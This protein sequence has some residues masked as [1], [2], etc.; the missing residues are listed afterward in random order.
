VVV[1][2]LAVTGL[3]VAGSSSPK[4]TKVTIQLK[5][6]TQSQF[7]G[8]YAAKA[9]GYYKAAGL[10]VNLKVGGPDIVNEQTVLSKQAEFGVDW[11][12]SLLANRD[13]GNDLVNIAQI[14][15]RSGTTEVT[16]K[17]SGIN[18]FK[19]MRGKKFGVWI[20]GNEFEQE[21][22]LVKNGMDPKKDV[23]LVKQDFTMVPFLNGEVDAASAMTYN[24][25]AQV[26][27]TKNPDTGK[28]VWYYQHLP[29][30]QWDF[31]WA[32]ERHVVRLPVRGS[33]RTVIV[34]AG[35][36][37]IFD[38]VEAEGGEYLF[39]MDLG[40]QNVVKSINPR[41]GVKTIDESLVPG[42][43][44]TKLVC[45]HAGAAK[46]WLPSS[47]DPSTKLLYIPLVES[48]M[49]LTPVAAGERG[50]LSTGVRFTLRPPPN[51]DGKYGRVQAINL[52]TQ[53][54]AWVTRQRAPETAGV[55]ATAGGV[56]FAGSLDRALVAY[57]SATGKE[58]WRTRLNDVPN[59]AP[60]S[61]SV[62]GKQYVALTVGNGGPQ[63]GTFIHLV[64]EIRNPPE[65]GA[66][67]WVFELPGR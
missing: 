60:I 17:K 48:C 56:V 31:D 33:T 59:S 37:A 54:V 53:K 58:L 11:F 62:N 14:Y 4:L 35:K 21:A 15:A 40:L 52:E 41:T 8:Y 57:D 12:P 9:K 46:S 7:A 20:F 28:L 10:D 67:L 13:Q 63:A 55:L 18:T 36:E 23:K 42:D 26:L 2:A 3:A 65:P 16:F 64:P 49:D 51:S 19:K 45:P 24:E 30:D 61:Y 44:Q 39:S 5:W 38:A 6:V 50:G 34:T 22:A 1:A 27:E 25:L 66:A 32:F 43:G 29:N 47:Y